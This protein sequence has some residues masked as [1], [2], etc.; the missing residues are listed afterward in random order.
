[1][2]NIETTMKGGR[3]LTSQGSPSLHYS[4]VKS[5]YVGRGEI[6]HMI[7][8]FQS[9][10]SVLEKLARQAQTENEIQSERPVLLFE[11]AIH[12]LT[13]AALLSAGFH[14]HKREWRRKRNAKP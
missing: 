7:S 13:Q 4:R 1:M 8:R 14:S 12:L 11:E 5:I 3:R 2:R 6:A 10:S 9:G